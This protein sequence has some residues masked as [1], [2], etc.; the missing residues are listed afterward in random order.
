M[1]ISS[2]SLTLTLLGR[3]CYC[4]PFTNEETEAREFK[5]FAKI[6]TVSKWQTHVLSHSVGFKLLL[7]MSHW[8]RKCGQHGRGHKEVCKGWAPYDFRTQFRVHGFKVLWED[9][10]MSPRISKGQ[11][12]SS[13]GDRTVPSSALWLLV[14]GPRWRLW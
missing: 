14:D 6:H 13:E 4:L 1:S 7:F 10:L 5:D 2:L 3:N 8:R 11:S 12:Q 9:K